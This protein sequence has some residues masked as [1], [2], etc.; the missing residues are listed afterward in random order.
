MGNQ[1]VGIAPSQIFPVEHYLTDHTDLQFDINLG[2]TRFFKVA[3]ARSQEGLIVVKVFAIHDPTLPLS[4]YRDRIEEIRSKLAS[5]TNCL[6]C[7][8][9][10]LTDRAGF[11]MRGYIKYSLYDRIS[12]RPFL[13]LLE[14]KWIAF[15]ILYALFQ[16][17][18][19]GIC[20]GD[21][22]LEN[23]LVTSWHWVLL[24]DF[25]SF[26]PTH[27]PED[28]P[29]D[30]SYF[31]DTSR[32]RTC[33]IAPERFMKSLASD[34]SQLLPSE[35]NIK[36]GDL[37]P[38]MDIFSAG[39]C[40]IELFT[41]GQPPFDFSQLLAYRSGEFSV[42]KHLEK[43]K[44]PGVR[45]LVQSMVQ[46]ESSK[47]CSAED[48]LSQERGK[49]FPEYFYTFLQS[50]MLIFSSS[51]PILSPDEKIERLKKDIKN[52]VDLMK[53]EDIKEEQN[54]EKEKEEKKTSRN[55]PLVIIT[56]L[57]TSCIRGLHLANSKIQCLEIL[58]EL[59]TH[60]SA[61]TVLDRILPY[62]LHLIQ[63]PSHRVRVSALHTLTK[64]LSLVQD[65]PP[66]D[67]NVFPE[68]ILPALAS[69]AHDEAVI[70]RTAFAENIAELAA[71]A[72]RFLEYCQVLSLSSAEPPRQS[73]DNELFAL[74]E[75]VQ[76]SVSALLTDPHNVVKQ[77][78]IENGITKLCVFFGK[79]KANDTLL[80]HMITFLNDKND[81]QLRMSFFKCIV[82]VATYIGVHCSPILSPLLQQG[83]TDP[84]EFVVR[85]A[86]N[87]MSALT[88]LS[89]LHKPTLY[90]LLA[91]T[92]CFLVHPSLW[93]RQA[94]VGFIKALAKTL[95]IVDVQC[96]VMS[97]IQPFL[98]TQVI[99]LDKE[100]LVLSALQPPVPRLVYDV[101]IHCQDVDLFL[102]TLAERQKARKL[103]SH[104]TLPSLSSKQNN[105]IRTLFSRLTSEGMTEQVEDQLLSM[106][107]H[108][109]KIHKYT[110]SMETSPPRESKIDLSSHRNTV[111][112]Q[113]IPL[114]RSD[115]P[116]SDNS[117]TISRNTNN[118]V[119]SDSQVSPQ[120]SMDTEYSIQERSYIQYRYAP[121]K[122][123]L[124]RLVSRRQELHAAATRAKDWAEHEAWIPPLPPPGWRLRG[125][126]VAHLHEH[127]A[128]VNRLV[129]VTETPLF[130]SCSSDGCIRI[131]DCAKME[132]RNI[133]NRSR[134]VY[135]GHSGALV[136][137]TLCHNNQ[138]VATISSSGA[139]LVVRIETSTNK[140]SILQSRQL[141]LHEEGA[142]VD[143]SHHGSGSQSVLV[144]ATMLGCI[145]GWDLRA[146]GI[147]WKL[148]ND[149]RKG[150]ISAMCLD[151]RQCYLALGTSSGYHT[152]WDL[153]FQ[154]PI[155]SFP[156]HPVDRSPQR[157]RR[158][159]RH[160]SESSWLLSASQG[161]NE[162][163]M[164]N[165]E[166]G[167]RQVILW[168][169]PA[170]PLST[171][172][173]SAHS[174]CGMFASNV[175]RSPFLLTG[176]SDQRVRYWDL[177][178]YDNSRLAIPAGSDT[179]GLNFTYKCR[180]IDGT[181]VVQEVQRGSGAPTKAPTGEESPRAG[182]DPPPPG[183][184]DGITDLAMCQASQCF[185]VSAAR[186]GVIKVWK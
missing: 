155:T 34:M 58:L 10:I 98:K 168:A 175:D 106:A 120:R 12:T 3:R 25:A 109:L 26:K 13:T 165:M 95:N 166:S 37:T 141:D 53:T 68:Y 162:V 105:A 42:D 183:H 83:L 181:N 126:L 185:L 101:V 1:L 119:S 18:R 102:Q 92:A 113:A 85:E 52:I 186:D 71:T 131:W 140:M 45:A 134:Q 142:A 124:R 117:V 182:P 8:R 114:S 51:T 35:E 46:R 50:Y 164:W 87:T 122:L 118:V 2:S 86:I 123:E 149:L 154:M 80:S 28:N 145:I 96:K 20:H 158:L 99:Q 40:L 22:K 121:C 104:P 148:E 59:A 23:I 157:I 47:R 127:K 39:C 177:E 178:S 143:I 151:S 133:A 103:S 70:V 64:C 21:I 56:S 110:N 144:Y 174:V 82:G 4:T 30:F 147:A 29:A 152:V 78:L 43:I 112:C 93:I 111:A 129:P 27:L 163:T 184:Y 81:K 91:E 62:I 44:D 90:D 31:F 94:I 60:T 19:L 176:G 180:M 169:S 107:K 150:V 11:L 137:M 100:V 63:D 74:H 88:E 41:D 33:Y 15:Q 6:P 54:G 132:G 16:C 146:P 66:S 170:P 14:K 125:S 153:R 179:Q 73:Y 130:A 17:H 138:S 69:V 161:H 57:V 115:Q 139:V 79:Q 75:M 65:I 24:S 48:Y 7:Q 38:A 5:A 128:A 67:T 172:Q 36:K 136:G 108:L 160:P 9:V 173:P 49:V 116:K 156:P 171:S 89:L 84:E 97:M 135:N 159:V 61:D 167:N 55:D 77:T 72:L 76:Q 32:R